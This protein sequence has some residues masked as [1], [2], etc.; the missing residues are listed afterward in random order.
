MHRAELAPPE[1]DGSGSTTAN[2]SRG[3]V[4][5]KVRG[6][7]MCIAHMHFL[8]PP[9]AWPQH[10]E[11]IPPY[12]VFCTTNLMRI[13]VQQNPAVLA[14]DKTGLRSAM[15]ATWEETEKSLEESKV[16]KLR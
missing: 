12:F 6:Y 13:Y 3:S 9:V 15:S 4:G 8:H 5:N 11:V 1:D 7:Y 14:Y 16:V 2:V 10:I